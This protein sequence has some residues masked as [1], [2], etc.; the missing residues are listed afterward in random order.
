[1]EVVFATLSET[2]TGIVHDIQA[3]AE[4]VKRHGALFVVDAVSG[5]GRGAPAS[6]TSGAWTW[7]SPAR[8]RRS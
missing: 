8:R 1:M 2:S 3:I 6:R 7:S 4:V 5:L